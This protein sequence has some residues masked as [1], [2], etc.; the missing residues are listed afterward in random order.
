MVRGGASESEGGSAQL[1]G[2]RAAAP[3]LS[4]CRPDTGPRG[5]VLS[6]EP[7]RADL[8]RAATTGP[9]AALRLRLSRGLPTLPAPFGI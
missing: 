4:R 3:R 1:G 6:V 5:Q 7:G 2:C 9:R 8:Q